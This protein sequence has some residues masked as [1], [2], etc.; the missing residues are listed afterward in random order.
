MKSFLGGLFNWYIRFVTQSAT[1]TAHFMA[2]AE[3]RELIKESLSKPGSL[4]KHGYKVYSQNDEDGI[5]AE[6]CKRI[7]IARG[8]FLELGVGDG[9]ENNTLNLLVNGWTG[10]WIEMQELKIDL[11]QEGLTI[12]RDFVTRENIVELVNKNV[13]NPHKLDLLSIDLDGNDYYIAECL[14]QFKPKIIIVEYNCKF[15]PPTNWVMP[16]N[17]SHSW[18]GTDYFGA[19]LQSFTD[20]ML[21]YDYRLVGCNATGVNAFF[22]QKSLA[23]NHFPTELT[24]EYLYQA[25]NYHL[26]RYFISGHMPSGRVLKGRNK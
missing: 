25:C 14:L 17:S 12:V 24:A 3:Y 8:T 9:M 6:I 5:I 22:V 4:L 13:P 18:D 2:T 20:L 16:Y 15:R 11:P 21:K 7:S 26:H 10:T 1:D 19:S 23:S